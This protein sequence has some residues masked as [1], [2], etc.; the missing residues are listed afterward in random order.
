MHNYICKKCNK[1]YKTPNGRIGNLKTHYA[2]HLQDVSDK[3]VSGKRKSETVRFRLGYI[4][5]IH[6]W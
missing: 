4:R 5:V 6:M 1:P 2:K 3:V